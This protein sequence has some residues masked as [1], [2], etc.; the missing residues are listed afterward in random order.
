METAI[1]IDMVDQAAGMLARAASLAQMTQADHV[2]CSQ[3][4]QIIAK[5]IQQTRENQAPKVVPAELSL[6]RQE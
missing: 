6:V 1:S 2:A 3:S 4:V 5:F